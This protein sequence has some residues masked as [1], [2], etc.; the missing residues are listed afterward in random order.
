L[1]KEGLRSEQVSRGYGGAAAVF[2]L[3]LLSLPV[4]V[5][6]DEVHFPVTVGLGTEIR[7]EFARV[8]ENCEL[9]TLGGKLA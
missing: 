1:A 7:K 5:P 8:K 4:V 3:E 6:E 2:E 9:K